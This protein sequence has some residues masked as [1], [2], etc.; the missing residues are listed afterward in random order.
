MVKVVCQGAGRHI[1]RSHWCIK[2]ENLINKTK[3][4]HKVVR[5]QEGEQ[6]KGICVR[7]VVNRY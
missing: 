4:H 1:S 7:F 2:T 3:F 6:N 5:C